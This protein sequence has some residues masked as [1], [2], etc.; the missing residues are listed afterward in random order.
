LRRRR[1]A[2]AIDANQ[3]LEGKM[4]A[5]DLT[6]LKA[7]LEKT[8]SAGDYGFIARGM[9]DS[10]ADFLHRTAA[11]G[12]GQRMLDVACGAGQITIPAA[13][14]GAEV[15]GID[16][17]EP[18]IEQARARAADEGLSAR[19]DV[20]DAEEMPYE[21]GTFDTVTSLIG[22]MFCPR[23][24]QAMAEMLRVTR[25]GGRIVLGNWTPEGF[26]G[27]MFRTVGKHNPP[28]DMPSPLLWGD[29]ETV[30]TRFGDAV[31]ELSIRRSALHFSYPDPVPQLVQSYL[32]YF[33][34][35]VQA[36]AALDADGQAALRAD[37][38][39]LWGRA[40]QVPDGSNT[41]VDGEILEIV[42]VKR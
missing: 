16:I 8:W 20:G 24:E 25:P 31:S 2:I 13:R 1:S 18:W 36:M 29:E 9:K 32:D 21:D 27:Q 26:I 14:A 3:P 42:A 28:P 38:E 34:P 4:N 5:I 10:A 40:N 30:R 6:T 12:P 23:P 39:A 11:P 22:A 41:E 15:V 33:G 7:G 35:A 19:F 17:A 37:L